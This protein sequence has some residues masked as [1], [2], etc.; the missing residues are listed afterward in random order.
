VGVIIDPDSPVYPYQQ[1]AAN[2]R[3]AITAGE[4]TGALPSLTALV[5]DT[6]L[7]KGTVQR[8]IQLLVDEGLVETARGRGMFVRHDR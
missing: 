1:L 6:G 7:S 4:I 8:A 5:M 2:L 3:E